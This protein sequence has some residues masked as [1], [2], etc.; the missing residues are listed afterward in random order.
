MTWSPEEADKDFNP[1]IDDEDIESPKEQL[2]FRKFK[3]KIM[4]A[5]LRNH[6]AQNP[7]NEKDIVAEICPEF[8]YQYAAGQHLSF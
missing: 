6:F 8:K 2:T 7:R 1:L 4:D 5:L 3:Y